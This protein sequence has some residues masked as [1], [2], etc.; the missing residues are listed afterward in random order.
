MSEN[1]VNRTLPV[2]R[3][4][5]RFHRYPVKVLW[6]ETFWA[7][8]DSIFAAFYSFCKVGE[9][10]VSLHGEMKIETFHQRRKAGAKIAE[11]YKT[12]YELTDN[13]LVPTG[14]RRIGLGADPRMVSDGENCYAYVIGYG[15]AGHPAFLYV[16]KDDSLRP[17]QAPDDFFWGKNWQPYLEDGR[18]FIVHELTPYRI[19]EVDLATCVLEE[20]HQG[21]TD[22]GLSAHHTHYSMLRGGA[23][24]IAE[25]DYVYGIG[26]ASTQPYKHFP[27]LWSSYRREAPVVQ[28]IDIFC[29]LVE[30]GFSILDPT[31]MWKDG[32]GL[33]FGLACSET[34]WFFEQRFL[35]LLLFI[36]AEGKYPNLPTLDDFLT[37]FEDHYTNGTPRLERHIFHCDQMQHDVAHTFEYGVR[38]SGMP[39]ALVYGPYIRPARAM[40]LAVELTYLT[41]HP[42]GGC[43][44]VFD[45][46]LSREDD[47]GEVEFVRAAECRLENTDREIA[48]AMLY[49]DTGKYIGWKI[50]FRV[51]VNEGIELNAFHVRTQ[52]IPGPIPAPAQ[53]PQK[54][55]DDA[56][57]S[58]SFTETMFH[59]AMSLLH[60]LRPR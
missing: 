60:F 19:Y 35:N 34:C 5:D 50:E 28:F 44:G 18:L 14:R 49:L 51:I 47:T 56:G 1:F 38:S 23:N 30:K 41:M 7:E 20:V 59:K 15:E 25:N 8:A 31:S 53:T 29:G 58:R 33:A 13:G 45:I 6:H 42:A 12:E 39:G 24:A 32:A 37:D 57:H 3:I 4:I 26:R 11:L 16:E 43:P 2:S 54:Q 40:F 10:Y 36:D 17:L 46:M 22:P 55:T 52:E 27:F 9:K 21:R 48:S